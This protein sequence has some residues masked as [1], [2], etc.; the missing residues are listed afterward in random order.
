MRGPFKPIK[1]NVPGLEICELLPQM[2]KVM[3]KL[4]IHRGFNHPN[5]DHYAAAHWLLSGYLGATGGDQR[6]RFPSM[7]S[8]S[9]RVLGARKPDIPPLRDHERRRLR[10]PRR[11]VP[12]RR[13]TTRSGRATRATAT[14]VR[15]S[16]SR[17][18]RT[19]S[20]YRGMDQVRV[21]RR[22]SLLRDVDRLRHDADRAVAQGQMDV[23]HRRP[24]R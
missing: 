24:W 6:P 11:R 4:T 23:M 14:R 16:P 12:G 17:R 1:T 10:L 2:A 9:S 5:N 13:R 21:V 20:P 18:P 8:I 22:Q 3:D 15:S 19:S 7:G